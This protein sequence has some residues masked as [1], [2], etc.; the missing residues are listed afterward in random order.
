MRGA[1]P[2]A[3]GL[4]VG[5]GII[6][7]DAGSTPGLAGAEHLGEDHPRVCGEHLARLN[8]CP[9]RAG[10]SPRM[11]GA[12]D[13]TRRGACGT[14][15]IPAYAGS[16]RRS[17]RHCPAIQD[18]PRVC[19]E[20]MIWQASSRDTS[21]SSPRMRGAHAVVRS[22]APVFRIIPAYAGSTGRSPVSPSWS[23]DHPR[24]CGEHEPG[25]YK[26][27]DGSRIIPAYA[28][29]TIWSNEGGRFL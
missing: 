7:A 18:H 25:I 6:P 16:T 28:G 26:G 12:P 1:R 10:S 22:A 4:L 15:I 5:G 19:G 2:H 17:D 14:G 24:V 9:P 8:P 29:S 13:R 23:R 21:G 27:A 3:D 11:R 20:H